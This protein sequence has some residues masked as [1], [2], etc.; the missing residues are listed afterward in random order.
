M[1]RIHSI[2]L[3]IASVLMLATTPAFAQSDDD[4]DPTT[5]RERNDSR[6]G[7][8]RAERS[9][10]R[11]A[12]KVE[13]MFPLATREDPKS[14]VSD[15]DQRT[16]QKILDL[17]Q[18]TDEEQQKALEEGDKY[19]AN[20]KVKGYPRAFVERV[21]GDVALNKDNDAGAIAHYQ[22]AIDADALSNDQHYQ[23]MLALAQTQM[24]ADQMELGLATLERM[25]SE[26]KT[27]NPD[28]V[29]VKAN[30]L[31]QLERYPEALALTKQLV[32]STP[33]PK[34]SWL[35]LLVAGYAESDQ[36]AE[37]AKIMQGLVARHPDDKTLLMNLAGLYQQAED[38]N[39]AVG[40]LN[41]MR[42][43]GLLDADRDY[44]ALYAMYANMDGHDADVIAVI[45]E[46][47]EKK[48]LQPSVEAYTVLGQANYFSEHIPEALAAYKK[49]AEIATDGEPSLNLARVY[50][51]ESQ[52]TNSKEAAQAALAKGIK[53]PGDAWVLIGRAEFGLDNR[54]GMAAA[55][56]K[57]A[58]YPETKASAEDWLRK[59]KVK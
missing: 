54:A 28:Y 58:T 18:G 31:Y 22:A 24:N 6:F 59:N 8:R 17:S 47:L 13:A 7:G 29:I 38:M 36:P 46:G 26:T 21:L 50:S 48:I 14:R 51:G 2:V 15:R 35:R 56:K 37:A 3:L 19:L 32:D 5:R 10:T 12:E 57:A 44:R 39:A 43:R 49:A 52:W 20:D 40:V 1:R 33:E 4:S 11:K 27:D 30:A 23:T 9:S 16:I 41:D 53:R 34:E 25:L 42:Q 45:N 55:M